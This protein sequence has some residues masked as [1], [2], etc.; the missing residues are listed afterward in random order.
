VATPT[1]LI[2]NSGNFQ[3]GQVSNAYRLAP[4]ILLIDENGA[5]MDGVSVQF[6]APS[7]GSSGSFPGPVLTFTGTTAGG[8]LLTTPTLTANATAG[9]WYLLAQVVSN[10]SVSVLFN[11]ANSSAAPVPTTLTR[12]NDNQSVNTNDFFASPRTNLKDQFN[13]NLEAYTLRFTPPGSGASGDFLGGNP[14]D[15]LTTRG[16]D[17]TPPT[18]QANGTAGAWLLNVL[19]VGTPSV[20]TN[21]HFTNTTPPAVATTLVL[22]SGGGQSQAIGVA[23]GAP[24]VV[25]V[26]D[27][28]GAHFTG[29]SVTFTLPSGSAHFA[30]G[31]T[32]VQVSDAMGN[33]TSPTI[34]A[35]TTAGAFVC[36]VSCPGCSSITPGLTTVDP[37]VATSLAYVSGGGQATSV[38]TPFGAALVAKALNGL[39]AGVSGVSVTFTAPGSGASLT[40]GG[41]NVQVKSTVS[42]GNAT[43]SVPVAN[44][45]SG[46]Y[47]VVASAA[48]LNSVNFMMTNGAAP[49]TTT[50]DALQY[51]EV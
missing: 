1:Q 6:V 10:H 9:S 5:P 44:S 30:S 3:A 24:I 19:V 38:S 4:Q 40:M 46:S 23:F 32:S 50:A 26:L 11:L 49:S 13:L 29:A 14:A 45:N 39:G 15:V 2:A 16:G 48:G 43:T 33:V 17:A 36:T 47:S 37:A 28:N 42:G 18:L 27:Q 12:N 51:V 25:Q 22:S 7:S 20:N 8:G 34:T 31:Q 41:S 35:G 21:Y